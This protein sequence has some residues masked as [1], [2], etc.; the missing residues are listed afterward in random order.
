[1]VCA[2]TALLMQCITTGAHITHTG[3]VATLLRH[4]P[5]YEAGVLCAAAA[6]SGAAAVGCCCS[7]ILVIRS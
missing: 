4:E 3:A 7:S 2:W 6:G 5:Y 1:M